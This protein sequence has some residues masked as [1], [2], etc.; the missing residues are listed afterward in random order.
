MVAR[1]IEIAED[2]RRQIRKGLL[3]INAR[4]AERAMALRYNVGRST[5]S[6]AFGILRDEGLIK[7][8]AK[9]GTVIQNQPNTPPPCWSKLLRTGTSPASSDDVL[10]SLKY[11]SGSGKRCITFGFN[12]EFMPYEPHRMAMKS[13]VENGFQDDYL[14]VFNISG[15]PILRKSIAEHVA[16]LGIDTAPENVIVFS[17]HIEAI[18]IAAIALL[19]IGSNLYCSERDILTFM[20]T[21]RSTGTNIREIPTDSEGPS[22][23][24]FQRMIRHKQA[25]LLYVNPVNSYPIGYSFTSKRMDEL[26]DV[27]ERCNVAVLENDFLRDLWIT[28]PPKPMKARNAEQVIYVGATANSYVTGFRVG[29]A[30]VPESLAT[31]ICDVKTQA[32]ASNNSGAEMIINEMLEKG[33]YQRYM[34]K[35]RAK[36]A[37]RIP[38]MN[39]ILLKYLDGAAKWNPDN[40]SVNV[41]LEFDEGVDVNRLI[42]DNPYFCL[43]GLSK[44]KKRNCIYTN[45]NGMTL[46]DFEEFVR[47]LSMGLPPPPH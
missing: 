37:E 40:F 3:P 10:N 33:Y 31:R 5:I 20:A 13:L 34:E 12:K 38:L 41:W 7:S 2:I 30:I 4:I 27:C 21:V 26:M 25:N 11:L 1:Y 6:A 36:L 8:K 42:A 47:Y 22:A 46:D 17:S 14:N 45:A 32:N 39:A 28:P 29:W 19:G 15:L 44:E 43:P 9:S 35:F 16:S 23:V 18:Y 24:E